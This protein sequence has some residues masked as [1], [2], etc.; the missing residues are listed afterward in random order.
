MRRQ[1]IPVIIRVF[2]ITALGAALFFGAQGCASLPEK[3]IWKNDDADQTKIERDRSKESE[4]TPKGLES[5]HE[6]PI[7][8]EEARRT[9]LSRPKVVN[10]EDLD[11]KQT[12][13]KYFDVVDKRSEANLAPVI[14][15]TAR[16]VRVVTYD[17]NS[18][19]KDYRMRFG[20]VWGRVIE[21]LLELPL[22]TVDRSS[23]VIVTDWIYDEA[24]AARG[25]LSFN[26]LGSQQL[27]IRYKYTIRILDRGNLTQI[28]VVPFAQVVKD[29]Q[30]APVKASIVVTDR[31]FSRV[32]RELAV[33][34]PSERN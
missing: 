16:A 6:T 4:V 21:A 17:N 33:P 3:L 18:V 7:T 30:W 5:G 1:N 9:A 22:N 29:R 12:N 15:K 8:S 23:G 2:S 10:I 13:K 31:M 20:V 11:S 32:D 34:L 24:N 25:L 26:P 19:Q 27:K 14:D 28:K